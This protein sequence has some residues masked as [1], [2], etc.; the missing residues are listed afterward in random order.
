MFAMADAWLGGK[1]DV[2]ECIA[3]TVTVPVKPEVGVPEISP[4]LRS[5][6]SPGMAEFNENV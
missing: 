3:F 1:A 4:L 6:F 5:T 2:L